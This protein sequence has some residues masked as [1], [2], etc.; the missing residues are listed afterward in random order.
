MVKHGLLQVNTQAQNPAA[1]ATSYTAKPTT[2][3]APT[4]AGS[5]GYGQYSNTATPQVSKPCMLPRLW[6]KAK[7]CRNV[8]EF[9]EER[10]VF[11]CLMVLL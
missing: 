1:Q 8:L 11:D 4:Q 2:S 5:Q 6:L 3:Q 9:V 10:G 7:V